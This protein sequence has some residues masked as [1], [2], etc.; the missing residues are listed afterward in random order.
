MMSKIRKGEQPVTTDWMNGV[1]VAFD[2]LKSLL[3]KATQGERNV[4]EQTS[5]LNHLQS[6]L[7]DAEKE[8]PNLENKSIQN[9]SGNE[10]ITN[11][12]TA[13]ISI[14]H[15]GK[16]NAQNT[17]IVNTPIIHNEQEIKTQT[18][19]K[20]NE[21]SILNEQKNKNQDNSSQETKT[22]T[23]QKINE[24]SVINE[25]ENNTQLSNNQNIENTLDSNELEEVIDDFL[26]ESHEI[27]EQLEIDLVALSDASQT[28]I[29]QRI[30]RNFHT[31][32]GNA[33]F[34][35]SYSIFAEISKIAHV[36]ED[37]IG[38]IQQGTQPI[39]TAWMNG[40]LSALDCLKF[41]FEQAE[42]GTRE[43]KPQIALLQ[44][45]Q[46]MLDELSQIQKQKKNDSIPIAEITSKITT[47]SKEEKKQFNRTILNQSHSLKDSKLSSQEIE[48]ILQ[49]FLNESQEI[50]EQLDK[51]LILL[52][53]ESTN[54]SLLD[55]IFRNWHTLK[56][57]TA[58]LGFSNISNIAHASEDVLKEICQGNIILSSN[59][60]EVLL[61]SIDYFKNFF[62]KLSNNILE[63]GDTK[64]IIQRLQRCITPT[65]TQRYVS[66][67]STDDEKEAS[68]IV[69][70]SSNEVKKIPPIIHQQSTSINEAHIVKNTEQTIRVD[71]TRLDALMN[72]AGELV[73]GRNRFNQVMKQLED[74]LDDDKLYQE[75]QSSLDLLNFITTDLQNAVLKTRMQP[76]GKIFNRFHRT[77]RDLAH[78]LGKEI[79][80]V[81]QGEETEL[82]KTVIDELG[83]PLTHMLR[84]SIDHG[85]ETPDIR[86]KNHKP[87]IGVISLTAYHQGNHIIITVQDDGKGMSRSKIQEKAIQQGLISSSE[88]Q[89]MSDQEIQNLIF[90]PGF[91]TAEKVTNVSGRGVGMDVVKTSIEKLHG[92]VEI[93][94]QENKGTI[95]V[96]RLPFTLAIIHT[97]Q[98]KIAEQI[99]AIPLHSIVETLRLSVHK[100]QTISGMSV[101]DFREQIIPLIY[102][103]DFFDLPS[104]NAN[105]EN[106]YI[107]VAEMAEKK[108]GL[109]VDDIVD[110]EEVVVKSMGK[111]LNNT[112][113]IS[114]ACIRGDGKV[115]LIID[116][117]GIFKLLPYTLN[118][119]NYVSSQKKSKTYSKNV[120]CVLIV[121]DS[122]SERKRTKLILESQKCFKIIEAMDGKD[123]L[124]KIFSYP[125]D[126]VLTDIEMPEFNGYQL[127]SKIREY[128]NFKHLPVI[129]ISSHKDMID[130]IRGMEAG[131]TLYLSKPFQEEDLLNAIKTVLS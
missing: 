50:I 73:L 15:S 121:E 127:T 13:N 45:L 111:L 30:F 124:N 5:L 86:K 66:T 60:L 4:E 80:L 64:T 16:S 58:F 54:R 35:N 46:T 40:I 130:R 2:C 119:E 108:V 52:E 48:E 93:H 128:K 74:K 28:E 101:I 42:K 99:F 19:Q 118:D 120:Y 95:F 59:I 129:A 113:G 81:V 117:A 31:I 85:I 68:I 79:T 112:P 98:V 14:E 57:N 32:K 18:N 8:L 43:I 106:I 3:E 65:H 92:S 84:N 37:M 9:A 69:Q 105:P 33:N 22:Q 87:A 24:Q 56:S 26:N 41:L 104:N 39:T 49:D 100:V 21:Q 27:I 122:R 20:I 67:F 34:F 17:S 76:I 77:V 29:V 109:V 107:V 6:M 103:S 63:E 90:M 7:N 91:S 126:L 1:L 78:Q 114:S 88:A 94:S 53:K 82:D 55:Q 75:I 62:Q 83:E 10:Q 38:K 44:K 110:Q 25:Q 71:S 89:L 12:Q 23:N 47:K 36:A 96:I 125:I 102:L 70:K 116:L 97:L 51:S 72:L 61:Q 131:I 115:T 11:S 123:A